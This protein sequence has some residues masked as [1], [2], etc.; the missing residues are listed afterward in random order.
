MEENPQSDRFTREAD[1]FDQIYANKAIFDDLLLSDD[2]KQKYTNP[3][4]GTIFSKK[5]YFHLLSPLKGKTVLEIACGDGIDACIAAHNG[6]E[7]YAYDVSPV[8]V[9]MTKQR[10]AA[11][12]L[13]DRVHAEVCAEIE[14]AFRGKQF[15]AVMGYAAL[16][17]LSLPGFGEKV[18]SRLNTGGVAVFAEPVINSQALQKIRNLIPYRPAG[19]SEDQ[20]P[21]SDTEIYELSKPFDRLNR[22]E[23]EFFARLHYLFYKYPRFVATLFAMDKYLMKIPIFRP[24]GSVVV[25]ALYRDR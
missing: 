21:L 16:H 2:D 19:V 12:G 14:E 17:H 13:S 6:A 23:F 5:Y 25:F 9:E 10:A 1:H 18:H 11:N 3:P 4:E 8:A 22:R 20:T 15:D 7:V 24:L